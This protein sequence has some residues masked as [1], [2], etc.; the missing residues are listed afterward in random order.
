MTNENISKM[1]ELADTVIKDVP[2]L[3]IL[4]CY[5]MKKIDKPINTEHLYDILITTGLVNYFY[6]QDSIAFL[7]EN[8]HIT[9]EKDDKNEENYVLM[10]KGRVCAKELQKYAPKSYRDNLLLAALKYFT[11]LKDEQ[12]VQVEYIEE[13][14]GC[15]VKAVCHDIGFNL[16]ELKL[17]A[18][19]MTQAK[20]IGEKIMQNPAGF[21][22]KL[23]DL[24]LNNEEITYDLTDN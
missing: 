4:I 22:G 11:R 12:E 15:Y 17:F 3:N 16:M 20:L 9:I 7:L 18:P 1:T 5:L 14:N 23:I 13:D 21:Y 6:Y 2:T 8:G 10:P 24:A 19:D